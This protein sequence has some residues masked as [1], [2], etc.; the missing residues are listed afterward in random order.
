MR[1]SRLI[2]HRGLAG[3]APENTLASIRLAAEQG[4]KWVEVDVTLLGDGT[5]VLFHD[6]RLNRTTDKAGRLSSLNRAA[7]AE[8]DAG[9]WFSDQFSGERIPQLGEALKLIKTLGLGLNLELKTNGCSASRLVDTVVK[10]IADVEFPGE[11]LLI[12]S[13]NYRALVNLSS[14]SD[15]QIGCLFERLPVNW[16]KRALRVGA[17]SIHLNGKKMSKNQVAQVKSAGYELYCYTVN[18]AA[19]S[20]RLINCGVDGVFSDFSLQLNCV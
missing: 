9:R 17:V 15:V 19:V 8:V 13:F 4:V 14:R 18:S 11:R 5:A 6:R 1:M 12:S 10:T 2:G 16:Q 20:S 3:Q 7:L